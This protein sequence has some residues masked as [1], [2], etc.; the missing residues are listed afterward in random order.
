MLED[1]VDLLMKHQEK[2]GPLEKTEDDDTTIVCAGCGAT[3]V[4]RGQK[5]VIQTKEFT[6]GLL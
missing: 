4:K 5:P 2:C 3:I 1:I 6:I